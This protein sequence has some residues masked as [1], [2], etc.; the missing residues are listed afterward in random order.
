MSKNIPTGAVG[1]KAGSKAKA[2]GSVQAYLEEFGYLEGK[3]LEGDEPGFEHDEVFMRRTSDD[4]V[5]D[6]PLTAT[7]GVLDDSTVE[8]L[9]RFQQFAGLEAT[10]QVDEVTRDAM[11]AKRCGNMDTSPV[12]E[13]VTGAGKWQTKH[14][15]YSFQNYTNDIPNSTIR[16]AIDEAFSFWSAE[17]PLRFRRVANGTTGDIIIRFVEGAHGDGYPFDGPSNVLAHAFYPFNPDPIRGD[18][19]F[20]DAES[21]TVNVPSAGFDLVTVAAHE[22][23]HALGLRHSADSSALMYWAYQGPHRYLSSDDIQGIQSLYGGP[24][25]LEN[26][27]WIHGNAALVEHPDRLQ[28]QRYY[29]FFNRVI[30]KPDTSNWIHFA[31]PTPVIEDGRRLV[32][33][34]FMLRATTGSSAI[35]RDVHIRDGNRV[36]ALLNGVDRSGNLGFEKFGVASMP[37]VRWGISV[38][39][40]F[41]FKAG[42]SGQRRVDLISAGFDYK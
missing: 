40:G 24:G 2:V 21:W 13:F 15:T 36:V 17:T 10:G 19:H 27:T 34:R 35:L 14:L 4:H 30:G 39:L 22:F 33:D 32:M 26:A 37:R 8:A 9:K 1:L 11:N 41:D 12:G 7:P 20:D 23:G 31:L 6:E 18:S 42:T 16:W 5:L 25:A 38:S 29:G 3:D 28:Y